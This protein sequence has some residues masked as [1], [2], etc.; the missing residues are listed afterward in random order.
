[1]QFRRVAPAVRSKLT[2]V[3]QP[4][5]AFENLKRLASKPGV[6]STL[7][8]SRSDGSIIHSTGLLASASSS[9]SRDPSSW[10]ST[11]R[12]FNGESVDTIRGGSDIPGNSGDE[13][14][15]NG[16][17]EIA[18]MAFAFA[19]EASTF[20]ESMDKSDEVKLLRLRT[21]KNEIVIVPGTSLTAFIEASC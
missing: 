8:L 11:S 5:A 7:I 21:R 14:E 18:R 15:G 17:E 12:T 20:T 6:Q 9:T 4:A 2:D 1:M 10:N 19:A 16:A 3:F 13:Q